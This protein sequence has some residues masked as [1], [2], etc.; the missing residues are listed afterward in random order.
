MHK[1]YFDTEWGQM[2]LRE[3]GEPG[4]PLLILMHWLPWSGAMYEPIAPHLTAKGWRVL[5]PDHLGYGRSDA[6]PGITGIEDLA[7]AMAA[8]IEAEA[9]GPA[10]L[11]GGHHSAMVGAELAITRPELVSR[12]VMDGSPAWPPEQKAAILE[13]VKEVPPPLDEAGTQLLWAWEKV[14][15]VR[16]VWDGDLAIGPENE[17]FLHDAII[18]YFASGIDPRGQRLLEYDMAAALPRIPVPCLALSA[19]RDPLADQHDKVLANVPNVIGHAFEG[20]HPLHR[21]HKDLNAAIAWA[22]TVS[23]FAK[24]NQVPERKSVLPDQS[25]YR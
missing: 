14:K 2:H 4:A 10:V 11:A 21:A 13:M 22:M 1:R 15:M 25:G 24:G 3:A 6:F 18:D 5:A 8:L 23:D 19:D 16:R 9:D 7:Q 17:A 12:L 20:V